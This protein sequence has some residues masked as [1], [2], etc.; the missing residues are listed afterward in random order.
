M[1]AQFR[2]DA[3]LNNAI[4]SSLDEVFN[5]DRKPGFLGE[6][7]ITELALGEEF[8]RFS[9]CRILPFPGDTNRLVYPA[10]RENKVLIH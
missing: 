10:R 2:D 5:S 6:I 1:I 3:R 4:V 8:P 7:K 9:N